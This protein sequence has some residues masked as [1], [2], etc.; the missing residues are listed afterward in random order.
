M[1]KKATQVRIPGGEHENLL[2][3]K[4]K[5]VLVITN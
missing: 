4:E 2:I 1:Q 3:A 5:F